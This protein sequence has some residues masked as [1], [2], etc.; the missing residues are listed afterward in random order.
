MAKRLMKWCIGCKWSEKPDISF[1]YNCLIQ[2]FQDRVTKK[3]A[4]FTPKEKL[5]KD[6]E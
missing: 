2:T 4:Y 6:D 5:I 3:P 1:C